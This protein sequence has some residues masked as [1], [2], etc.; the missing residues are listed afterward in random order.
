MVLAVIAAVS[1]ITFVLFP[2]LVLHRALAT[3]VL[4]LDAEKSSYHLTE[5]DLLV[6]LKR[7]A[8]NI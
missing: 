8:P 7:N 3:R 2:G 5:I 4:A 1:Q 6:L